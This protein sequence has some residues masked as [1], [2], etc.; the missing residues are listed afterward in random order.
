MVVHIGTGL[1]GVADNH[2][3]LLR[4][5]GGAAHHVAHHS[6]HARF[7]EGFVEAKMDDEAVAITAPRR[8]T[9]CTR[10]VSPARRV[11]VAE[12]DIGSR[13]DDD[14][15]CGVRSWREIGLAPDVSV[16]A[17]HR[18]RGDRRAVSLGALERD[19]HGRE[20]ERGVALD[21]DLHL[22]DAGP[23]RRLG[24]G[25]R[26]R[27]DRLGRWRRRELSKLERVLEALRTASELAHA[28]LFDEYLIELRGGRDVRAERHRLTVAE[29]VA[30]C[31]DAVLGAFAAGDA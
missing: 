26:R 13:R 19:R 14:G 22:E 24:R 11:A 9:I 4:V 27:R 23:D 20:V 2:D 15:P 7:D 10:C 18:R 1:V 31:L 12:P 25:L 6:A 21:G 3:L 5:G 16:R 30:Q 17:R 28:H 8:S 29:L